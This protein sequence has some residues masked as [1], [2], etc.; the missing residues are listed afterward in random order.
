M[1]W[2][3]GSGD[4]A[5][6]SRKPP[7]TMA[8]HQK[9]TS[10]HPGRLVVPASID[11]DGDTPPVHASG[12]PFARLDSTATADGDAM[13]VAW[14]TGI[15]LQSPTRTHPLVQRQGPATRRCRRTRPGLEQG[16]GAGRP[17][18]VQPGRWVRSAGPAPSSS[19]VVDLVSKYPREGVP[20]AADRLHQD[21]EV[22]DPP[23]C[24][25]RDENTAAFVGAQ[26]TD[27]FDPRRGR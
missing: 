23:P 19:K 20:K 16:P 17:H 7:I 1:T 9:R 3:S 10:G 13:T 21:R 27:R 25:G 4:S 18:A 14:R 11:D 15:I 2:G 24:R 6:G 12:G 26:V 8:E 5:R 22:Y